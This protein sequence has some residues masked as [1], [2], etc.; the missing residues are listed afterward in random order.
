MGRLITIL[1]FIF[2]SAFHVSGISPGSSAN[3]TT[4]PVPQ[5][6][7]AH[8]PFFCFRDSLLSFG[9][10]KGLV[11]SFCINIKEQ[12]LAPFKMNGPQLAGF[13]TGALI[14]YG[15]IQNDAQLDENYFR[16]MKSKSE[17]VN[18][19]S[20]RVTMLGESYAGYFLISYAGYSF[21]SKDYKAWRTSVLAT[22]ACLSAG[23]W[24][25]IGKMF[26]SRERPSAAYWS[27]V[28]GGRWRWFV[29]PFSDLYK[30]KNVSSFDAFPS[31]HT[32]A[33]FS[34]ATVF[35]MQYSDRLAVPIS[36]YTIATM[37]G[38]SR[39]SEHEHWVSDVFLGGIIGYL[40]G[41]QVV[42]HDRKV[43]AAFPSPFSSIKKKKL[44]WNVEP[45]E[46]GLGLIANW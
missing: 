7:V 34:I 16:Y 3:D 9:S 44:K 45:T 41:R 19:I 11:P 21:L 18:Q 39:L 5:S 22:Q 17:T 24:V 12:F 35:A 29:S 33:A 14:T 28:E 40:C 8:E 4:L 27:E 43:F 10:H 32:S 38:V 6:P 25:R 23:I 36:A 30:S 46:N 37:V 20:P 13:A 31:G 1:F 15:L 2:I 42:M 26:T